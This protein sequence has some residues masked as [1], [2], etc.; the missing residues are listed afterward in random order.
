MRQKSVLL[1]FV[2]AV[3]LVHKH[4]GALGVQAGAGDFGFI[5]GFADVFDA[6]QHRTDAQKLRLKRIGHQAGDGGF[7]HARR[8][9]QN[10]AVRL[11]RLESQAQGHA[12]TQQMLLANH[13][14]Q[15]AR[16]QALCQGRLGR[17][18][19]RFHDTSPARFKV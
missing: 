13:L 18:G 15:V 17:H 16:A 2:E 11:A 8:S 6:P 12:F 4:D 10:A 19:S 7:A 9:P 14:T 3:H 5:Y 1:A